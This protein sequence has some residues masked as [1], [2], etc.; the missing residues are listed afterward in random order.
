MEQVPGDMPWFKGM[1]EAIEVAEMPES[2]MRKELRP[3]RTKACRAVCTRSIPACKFTH[4]PAIFTFIPCGHS[5]IM[6]DG[7]K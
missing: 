7:I 1:K 2:K 5:L 3:N 6:E 4:A